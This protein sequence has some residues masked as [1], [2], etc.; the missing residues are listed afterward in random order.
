[1]WLFGGM[2]SFQ[3]CSVVLLLGKA[4]R[5]R[6]LDKNKAPSRGN[7]LET[8]VEAMLDLELGLQGTQELAVGHGI[9][10]KTLFWRLTR[11]LVSR[12]PRIRFFILRCLL[13]CNENFKALYFIF[14]D[15]IFKSLHPMWDSNLQ[16]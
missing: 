7:G 1:M 12:I 2:A 9:W 11:I 8:V 13:F 10:T 5:Q 4:F 3:F 14:K 16:P 6:G 15:F